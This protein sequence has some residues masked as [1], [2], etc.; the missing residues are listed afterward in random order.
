MVSEWIVQN[1]KSVIQTHSQ[2]TGKV[3]QYSNSVQKVLSLV[4][5]IN[6]SSIKNQTSS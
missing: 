1:G 3:N 2:S 6:I 4:Y 5:Q